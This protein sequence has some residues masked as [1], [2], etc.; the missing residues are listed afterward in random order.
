M[1]IEFSMNQSNFYAISHGQSI[2]PCNSDLLQNAR[3]T[4][5][6]MVISV[7]GIL[8]FFYSMFLPIRF[9]V[10]YLGLGHRKY[11]RQY[12]VCTALLK[13]IPPLLVTTSFSESLIPQI[14][15]HIREFRYS[16]HILPIINCLKRLRNTHISLKHV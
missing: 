3:I 14:Y 11:Q 5:A 10:N 9:W 4:A 12:I 16:R 8:L 2:V 7:T 13:K 15:W 1:H 6:V